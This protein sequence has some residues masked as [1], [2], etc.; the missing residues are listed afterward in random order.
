MGKKTENTGFE[1]A[2]CGKSV[3]KAANGTYRNHC[4]SCLFSQ[5]ADV[6]PGDRLSDCMGLMEPAGFSYH[7]Q[8]GWQVTH[9]CLTCGFER[10]NILC[11]DDDM[12]IV[13]DLMKR[14]AY[15]RSG[16]T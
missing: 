3:E 2:N 4:P 12:E 8:K 5:H 13:Y 1:C 10:R 6:E 9:K 7:T 15:S 14:E 11:T 16:S